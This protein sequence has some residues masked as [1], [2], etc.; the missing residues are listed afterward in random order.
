MLPELTR[1][2][3]KIGGSA[4]RSH[5]PDAK[6]RF[7]QVAKAAQYPNRPRGTKIRYKNVGFCRGGQ[8][9]NRLM[10]DRGKA[11]GH[12]LAPRCFALPNRL[13]GRSGLGADAISY[14]NGHEDQA[15]G[16]NP[17]WRPSRQPSQLPI[18]SKFARCK[19]IFRKFPRP[20]ANQVRDGLFAV[21]RAAF[22]QE[23]SSHLPKEIP[24][25]RNSLKQ[26]LRGG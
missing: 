4:P 21:L 16:K 19:R 11:R 24:N 23:S 3:R 6:N 7:A 25:W 15:L 18:R 20:N 10:G 9:G 12:N 5:L 14:R 8:R 22:C 26:K 17:A 13:I 1:G 2:C